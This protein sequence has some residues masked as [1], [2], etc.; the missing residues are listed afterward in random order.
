MTQA[1]INTPHNIPDTNVGVENTVTDT[2]SAAQ[3]DNKLQKRRK[4]VIYGLILTLLGWI[5]MI[6][7]PWVSMA[8]T[9][10]GLVTSVIGVRIP[11]G[12]RRDLAITAIIA[13]G[14]LI[15]VFLIFIIGLSLI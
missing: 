12:P 3:N 2:N 6:P 7:A 15:L 14:V 5:L 10:A 4:A 8:V 9:V 13:S 1:S 11:A